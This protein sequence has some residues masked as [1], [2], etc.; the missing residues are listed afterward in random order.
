[1]L[2]VM[3]PEEMTFPYT[4]GMEL[5]DAESGERR[6]VDAATLQR[7]YRAAVAGFLERC[8]T[9]AHRDGVDYALMSTGVPPER[10]LRDY[11]VRRGAKHQS[12]NAAL[13]ELR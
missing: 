13:K 5:E 9:L 4:G 8:R 3:S 12:G 2:Q 11:L 10:V 6:L 1:M 7:D